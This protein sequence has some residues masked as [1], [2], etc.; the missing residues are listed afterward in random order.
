MII[1]KFYKSILSFFFVLLLSFVPVDETEKIVFM[2]IPH[3]DKIV[4]F[5]MYFVLTFFL[6]YDI[7]INTKKPIKTYILSALLFIILFSGIIEIIQ[8][9]FISG[10]FGS[11]YDFFSN[12]LGSINGLLALFFFSK[13]IKKSNL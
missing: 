12:I 3:F 5:G 11:F 6:F 10:R 8:E 1:K 9:I 7:Q 13:I 2:N 4:H